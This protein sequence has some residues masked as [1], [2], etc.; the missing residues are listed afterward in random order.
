MDIDYEHLEANVADGTLRLSLESELRDGFRQMHEAGEPL[1]PAS[2]YATKIAE[3][4]DRGADR[5]VPSELKWVIY[6][7]VLTACEDAR[8]AVLGD[9]PPLH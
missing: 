9:P 4:I 8:R 7:E 1:P 5:E 3:I 6:Q 2:W